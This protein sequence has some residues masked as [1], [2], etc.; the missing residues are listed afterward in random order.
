MITPRNLIEY[1][2]A[3]PF[4]PFRV[5]TASGQTFDVRHPENIAVSR[6]SAKIFTR[7]DDPADGEHWRD[8]S[9]MLME[10]VEPLDAPTARTQS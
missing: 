8:V 1:V 4:R 7:L 3:E 5:N 6:T 2:S 9:L 10:S